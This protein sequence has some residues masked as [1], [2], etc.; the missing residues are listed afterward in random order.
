[1]PVSASIDSPCAPGYD[2]RREAEAVQGAGPQVSRDQAGLQCHGGAGRA[3]EGPSGRAL[4][5]ASQKGGCNLRDFPSQ[6][7]SWGWEDPRH[8]SYRCGLGT[9]VDIFVVWLCL[10]TR[11]PPT[12]SCPSSLSNLGVKAPF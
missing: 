11:G 3:R 7:H 10:K 1:M 8:H 12:C 5:W 4:K 2:W 6:D 9:E